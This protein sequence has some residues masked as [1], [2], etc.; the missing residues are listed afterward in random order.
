LDEPFQMTTHS[1]QT[2]GIIAS[3]SQLNMLRA[4]SSIFALF[5]VRALIILLGTHHNSQVLFSWAPSELVSSQLVLT[6]QAIFL[7]G[8]S[9]PL[10][11]TDLHKICVDSVFMSP[12]VSGMKLCHLFSA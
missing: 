3:D 5:A 10:V 11:H 1:Y 2:K 7:P 6:P 9:F 12:N 4:S 8:V